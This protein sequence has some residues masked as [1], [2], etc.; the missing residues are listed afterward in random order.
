MKALP[1]YLFIFLYFLAQQV[2]FAQSPINRLSESLV[3]YNQEFPWEKIYLHTDKPHYFLNDTIWIK[4]YGLIESGKEL[5]EAT[6]T[7]PLYV[8]LIDGKFNKLVNQIIIKME[9]GT[10]Q[11]DFILPRDLVPGAYTIRAYTQWMRNF[12]PETFFQKDIWVGEFGEGWE[13]RSREPELKLNF[14]PEGGN[15]IEGL[16]SKVGFKATNVYGKGTDVIGYVLDEKRDTLLRFES[17]YLGMGSFTFTPQHGQN[18]EV[19]A[20]SVDKD[21][22]RFR[23]AEIQ[24]LGHVLAI[25][26]LVSEDE[27]EITITHNLK[28]GGMG[29]KLILLGQSKGKIV[30]QKEFDGSKRINQIK[31]FKD[32]FMPGLVT[33]TLMDEETTLLAERLVYLLP[34][35]AGSASFKT[36]KDTYKPKEMVRMEIDVVDEFDGPI[37][38][39]FSL[40]ITDAYQV[41]HLEHSENIYSYLQLSS[42]VRGE[43]EDPYYYFNIENPNAERYLDNLLLTQGWRR[44]SWEHLSRL[45]QTPTYPF[46]PGLS[47]T[48]KVYKVNDKPLEEPHDLTLMIDHRFGL[49]FLHEGVTDE[50]GN[51]SFIGLDFQDSAA[52]YLQAYIGKEKKSGTIKE[53]KNNEVKIQMAEIPAITKSNYVRFP[54]KDSFLDYDDYMVTV[55]E[56]KDLMEQFVLSRE[57]ELGEVTVRGRRSS[58]LPDNRAIQYNNNPDRSLAV[59]EDFYNFQNI[60][61]LLRGRFPGVNVTGDVFSIN[62]PPAVLIRGGAISGSG[63]TGATFYLDGNPAMIELIASLPVPEI[64]RIDILQSLNKSAVYGADGAG[65]VINVLTKSGNPNRDFSKEPTIGNAALISKGYAPVREFYT[66][67]EIPDFNAPISIDFRSTIFWEPNIN[68]NE[69]GKATIEFPLSEG[70]PEVQVTLEGISNTGDPIRAIYQFKVQ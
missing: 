14:F 31:I 37:A 4:A 49:P 1:I 40:S 64:E 15:L 28:E 10:G 59:T 68:T 66:P 3:K 48:G 51:F 60:F 34:F 19:L 5:P 61:Q 18:Y 69:R 58:L 25:D 32:D 62:P 54:Q 30:Y 57:I 8:D 26:P 27:I 7:V 33:F 11:G 56:A 12:G 42:E 13:F 35:A 46:E 23:F 45:N 9:E 24:R 17:E 20:K 53:V 38:G 50:M 70:S 67:S 65:G 29:K 47:L 63:L 16:E 55:K 36:E 43:I 6:P 22:T 2:I 52:V 44:F 21:W 39:N 41:M